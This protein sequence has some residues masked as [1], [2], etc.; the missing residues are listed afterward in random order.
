M[1][2]VAKN[3]HHT[4]QSSNAITRP[5]KYEFLVE[6]ASV[7]STSSLSIAASS[8][9]RR[10]A[11]ARS[12]RVSQVALLSGKSGRTSVAPMATKIVKAPSTKKSH[13]HA[14]NPQIPSI[15]SR[16][17]DAKR[18][19]NALLM[20]LPQY[21]RAVLCESSFRLYHQSA[22]EKRSFYKSEEKASGDGTKKVGSKTSED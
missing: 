16:I 15:T 10:R 11:R 21:R 22:R 6:E 9:I 20:R 13:R 4:F 18:E 19:P 3:N 17:A 5:D 8:I 12:A 14:A 1:L 2:P 7:T